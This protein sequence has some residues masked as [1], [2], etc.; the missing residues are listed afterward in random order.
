MALPRVRQHVNP[1]SD[2]YSSPAPLPQWEAVYGNLAQ[3]LL[4]DIGSA[5][6]TFLLSMAQQY[7]QRNFLGLEIRASLAEDASRKS[8][9]L[10]LTN[11]HFMFCNVTPS[12][13]TLLA[14]LPKGRLDQVTIQFPDPWFK[15]RHQKRRVVQ[16]ALVEAI[17]THLAPGG[18][19]FL[20]SDIESVALDM[21]DRFIAHPGFAA[22][23]GKIDSPFPVMTEREMM[24][25]ERGEPVYRF[26][27][28]RR[29]GP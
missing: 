15:K 14:S 18:F 6:G 27:F 23:E 21:R 7:P 13:A 20:Q 19:A 12:L 4:L 16:P 9:Q 24:T 3:P 11:L 1:L 25:I 22:R 28:D 2:R 8:H 17:A 29:Y 5:K 26:Q 10:G